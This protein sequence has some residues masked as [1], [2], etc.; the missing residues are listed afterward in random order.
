MQFGLSQAIVY[1]KIVHKYRKRV[2][3]YDFLLVR[4]KVMYETRG[5]WPHG[6]SL[7][8]MVKYGIHKHGFTNTF[9]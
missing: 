3:K 9:S 5:E 2:F 6:A 1:E 8:T 7:K 4:H